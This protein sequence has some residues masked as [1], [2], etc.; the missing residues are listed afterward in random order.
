MADPKVMPINDKPVPVGTVEEAV[1]EGLDP[2]TYACCARPDAYRGVKGC[3]WFD[4][5]RVSAKGQNGP[6]RYGLELIS[7]PVMGNFISRF[8]ADCMWIAD[9]IDDIEDNKGSL[10]VLADEGESYQTIR[11]ILVDNNTN[12]ESVN[13]FNAQARREER[14]VNVEVKPWPRPGQNKDLL[15]DRLRAETLLAEK[16]RRSS[17]QLTRNLGLGGDTP[18]DKRGSAR[19]E[20][21]KADGGGKS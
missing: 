17:D 9:H 8:S 11:S 4:K 2:A 14:L 6:K 7:G 18:L 19:N 1:K 16:E 10:R 5:C 21:S 12:E 20:R 13:P 15:R 3:E